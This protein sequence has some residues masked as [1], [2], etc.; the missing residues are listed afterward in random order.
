MRLKTLAM[1][2]LIGAVLIGVGT[3][4]A[5]DT[6]EDWITTLNV[7]LALLNKLGTDSMHVDVDSNA[8]AVTLTPAKPIRPTLYQMSAW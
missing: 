4:N 8:G 7:K 3:A 1:M 6:K 5:A 2:A